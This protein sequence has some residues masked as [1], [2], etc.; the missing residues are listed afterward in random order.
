MIVADALLVLAAAVLAILG[1][2]GVLSE[3]LHYRRAGAA[4]PPF[5]G[6]PPSVSILKPCKGEDPDLFENLSSW[7]RLE[8]GGAPVE[9]LIGVADPGDPAVEVA[10]RVAR[11]HPGRVRLV[12]AGPAADPAVNPKVHN[13]VA[14]EREATGEVLVVADSN[15]RAPPDALERLLRPLAD[16]GVSATFSLFRSPVGPDAPPATRL[17][18]AIFSTVVLPAIAGAYRCFGTANLLGKAMLVRRSALRELGGWA[19]YARVLVED[20]CLGLDLRRRGHRIALTDGLVEVR[21]GRM[22]LHQLWDHEMRWMVLHRVRVP[23]VPVGMALWNPWLLAIAAAVASGAGLARAPAAL[24]LSA[25]FTGAIKL[26]PFLR[27]GGRPSGAWLLPLVE[28]LML[29]LA[30]GV[31]LQREVHWRG[32]RFLLAR[33]SRIAGVRPVGGPGRMMGGMKMKA[34][35][36]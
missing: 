32:Q 6:T 3:W 18:S 31:W 25:L 7:A 24:G 30:V 8:G 10:R 4:P 12:I 16:P 21:L 28:A 36:T 14:L 34:E 5:P 19:S 29:A 27:H 15:V 1:A 9:V 33:G 35:R 26:V 2:A 11:E 17:Q 20:A 22:T 23:L 13:L